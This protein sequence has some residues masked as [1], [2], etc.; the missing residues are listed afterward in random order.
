MSDKIILHIADHCIETEAKNE[1]RRL[2]DA[3]F[4]TDDVEGQLESKIELLRD[5]IEK[6]DFPGLRSRDPRLT[7][8]V[9]SWVTL[10]R[11]TDGKVTLLMQDG[12]PE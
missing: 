8:D 2:M 5:F 9:E 6:S 11:G 7:G 10:K 3:Y 12:R 1:F 4:T